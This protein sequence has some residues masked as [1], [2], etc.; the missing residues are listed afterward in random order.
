MLSDLFWEFSW[1]FQVHSSKLQEKLKIALE[2]IYPGTK[3]LCNYRDDRL[4][5]EDTNY[6]MEFDLFLPSLNLAFEYQGNNIIFMA[7]IRNIKQGIQHY[8]RNY[9]FGGNSALEIRKNKDL[10]KI[11]ECS[12]H[13]IEI[14]TVPYTWDGDIQSLKK[15]IS[16]QSKIGMD[17]QE[18]QPTELLDV[19]YSRKSL[20]NSSTISPKLFI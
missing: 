1:N 5:Y 14:V 18:I 10:S 19:H 13:N 6:M 16:Q 20:S 9:H 2:E 3:I 12:K 7:Y 15:I 11:R 8:E 17:Q 4:R